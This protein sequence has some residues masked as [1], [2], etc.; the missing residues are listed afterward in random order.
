MPKILKC[1]SRDPPEKRST[2][3]RIIYVSVCVVAH[4]TN[5][6]IHTSK[7]LICICREGEG[8]DANERVPFPKKILR[9]PQ[10]NWKIS[11]ILIRVSPLFHEPPFQ[12]VCLRLWGSSYEVEIAC[13]PKNRPKRIVLHFSLNSVQ[14]NALFLLVLAGK[15]FVFFSLFDLWYIYNSNSHLIC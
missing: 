3:C 1:F 4:K 12:V 5:S 9:K 14:K 11:I 10:K 15:F 7:F 2:S 8:I 13:V 6:F